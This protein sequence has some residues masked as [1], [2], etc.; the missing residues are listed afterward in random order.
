[1]AVLYYQ[2][3]GSYRFTTDDKRVIYLDPYAGGGYNVPGDLILVTHQHSDHNAVRLCAQKQD[4]RIITNREALAGGRHNEFD[5]GWVRV[6]AVQAANKNHD[7]NECVGYLLF[8][9]GLGIYC[10]GDTSYTA[11]MAE[12]AALHL[13][14]ALLPVDGIFNMNLDEAAECARVIG[15]AHNIPVHLKP[16]IL[17]NKNRYSRR[18][19]DSW[20]APNK[21]VVEPGRSIELTRGQEA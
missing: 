18:M 3:H 2:G 7:P 1:M 13:D 21:L 9:D 20:T 16:P 11:Q 6:Q 14:Y 19:A 4:C 12:L 8:F 15:A 17:F 5:L 10:S